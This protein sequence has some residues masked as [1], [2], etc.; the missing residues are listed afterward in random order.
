MSVIT[1][2]NT[3]IGKL[4]LGGWQPWISRMPCLHEPCTLINR[5]PPIGATLQNVTILQTS[6]TVQGSGGED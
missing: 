1:D 6:S 4:F 5:V 2:N 3:H